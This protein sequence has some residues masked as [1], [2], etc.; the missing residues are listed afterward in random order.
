MVLGF[1]DQL[2]FN[3][4]VRENLSHVLITLC[5]RHNYLDLQSPG[6]FLVLSCAIF[7][8]FSLDISNYQFV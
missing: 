3:G 2:F 5:L 7:L 1:F 4:N 8:C 6:M